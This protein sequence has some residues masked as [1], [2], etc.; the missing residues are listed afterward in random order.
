MQQWGDCPSLD[1]L[2]NVFNSHQ[3]PISV[4]VSSI[5]KG[6]KKYVVYSC[7][8]LMLVG[9]ATNAPD[10]HAEPPAAGVLVS[11]ALMGS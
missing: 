5:Y 10:Q 9:S 1:Q 3:L 7:M 4:S 2:I 6:W 11:P 8:H